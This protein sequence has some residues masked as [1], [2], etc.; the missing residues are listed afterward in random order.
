M[1]E[2]AMLTTDE[3][4]AKLRMTPRAVTKMAAAGR[5]PGAHKIAGSRWRFDLY[6]LTGWIKDSERRRDTWQP[7]TSAAKSGGVAP[8]VTGES[9][10][11]RLE[12]ALRRWR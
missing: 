11:A 2:R 6:K 5:I 9:S 7:S 3:V 1:A 8:N 4:A 10:A 12:Q